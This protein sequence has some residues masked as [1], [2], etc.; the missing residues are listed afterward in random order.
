MSVGVVSAD[1]GETHS[2]LAECKW[3]TLGIAADLDE[4]DAVLAEDLSNSD[5]KSLIAFALDQAW[6]MSVRDMCNVQRVLTWQRTH[7]WMA[8]SEPGRPRP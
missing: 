3:H 2:E 4:D 8:D 6:R 1:P 5:L 7:S